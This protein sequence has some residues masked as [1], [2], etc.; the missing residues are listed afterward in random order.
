MFNAGLWKLGELALPEGGVL[1]LKGAET[2]VFR[3]SGRVETRKGRGSIERT[4]SHSRVKMPS[5]PRCPLG[6]REPPGQAL[7]PRPRK[8]L[9]RGRDDMPGLQRAARGLAPGDRGRF[10]SCV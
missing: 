4:P 1:F 2:M 7:G 9:R 6:L 5:L 3:D 10:Y 8:G